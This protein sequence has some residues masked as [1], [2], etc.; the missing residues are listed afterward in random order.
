M[1]RTF[2][3]WYS[4]QGK[5]V[6]AKKKTAALLWIEILVVYVVLKGRSVYNGWWVDL[7]YSPHNWVVY[8]HP[9]KIPKQPG[10][11]F[12]NVAQFS[13][14]CHLK[15]SPWHSRCVESG[16]KLR[17]VWIGIRGD[18]EK[19]IPFFLC[20]KNARKFTDAQE[21]L[22]SASFA[23]TFG[24]GFVDND[25]WC[26]KK[27]S[28]QE[29]K[30]PWKVQISSETLLTLGRMGGFSMVFPSRFEF[31]PHFS[32]LSA[33]GPL[34]ASVFDMQALPAQALLATLGANK[35]RLEAL[36][37]WTQHW[38]KCIAE[39]FWISLISWFLHKKKKQGFIEGICSPR[40]PSHHLLPA[41][42]RVSENPQFFLLSQG[43]YLVVDVGES[44]PKNSHTKELK[45]HHQPKT[46]VYCILSPLF[47]PQKAP[48]KKVAN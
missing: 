41:K 27:N 42:M 40:S 28:Q 44:Y 25:F 30:H 8:D 31:L 4:P 6:S 33:T 37:F 45:V 23:H 11:H 12:Y 14:S 19:N 18:A 5:K 43:L 24:S 3:I 22:E 35:K 47:R 26:P 1:Y 46:L 34:W 15:F 13:G 7:L 36:N 29:Q 38:S 21:N 48:T 39:I 10:F 32:L 2:R 16:E 17:P 9:K 20:L